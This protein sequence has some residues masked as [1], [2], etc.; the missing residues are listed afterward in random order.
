[1]NIEH[2]ATISRK[3][4]V[5]NNSW[6]GINAYIQGE[7]HIGD[8]VMMGPDCCIWTINHESSDIS[9]PMCTQ[10]SKKEKTVYI[11]NDVRIGSRV[12]ILQ[13]VHIGNGV[14]NGAGAVVSKYIP[15]MAVAVGNPAQII[16]YRN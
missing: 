10:G 15:D 2:G 6:I 14:I 16:K 1:M 8:Y 12:M 7:T 13:G 5:G 11:G 9:V 4:Y 3:I